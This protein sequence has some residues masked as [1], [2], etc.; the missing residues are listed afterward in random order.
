MSRRRHQVREQYLQRFLA[1]TWYA[2]ADNKFVRKTAVVAPV[3]FH[4]RGRGIADEPVSF[5]LSLPL[6]LP[7]WAAS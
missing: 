7:A 4:R 2:L 1:V 5:L 6:E 3:S